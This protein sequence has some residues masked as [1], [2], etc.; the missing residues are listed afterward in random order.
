MPGKP[1]Y[2]T[3]INVVGDFAAADAIVNQIAAAIAA[4]A[5]GLS[6]TKILSVDGANHNA[7]RYD[8][9]Y[10]EYQSAAGAVILDLALAF[11]RVAVLVPSVTPIDI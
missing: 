1:G 7:L 4:F 9:D 6:V 3:Q 10:V 5:A 2:R 8:L 11:R